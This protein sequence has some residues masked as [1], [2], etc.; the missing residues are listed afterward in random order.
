MWILKI[1]RR[2]IEQNVYFHILITILTFYF[3]FLLILYFNFATFTTIKNRLTDKEL[4]IKKIE[5]GS[6]SSQRMLVHR[7]SDQF[8][9]Q[10]NCSTITSQPGQPNSA[11]SNNS[12]NNSSKL[13]LKCFTNQNY[14]SLNVISGNQVDFNNNAGNGNFLRNS[15][16]KKLNRRCSLCSCHIDRH[17]KK[18]SI[19]KYNNSYHFSITKQNFNGLMSSLT[20]KSFHKTFIEKLQQ[21]HKEGLTKN[22]TFVF[23]E[24]KLIKLLLT[25]NICFGGCWLPI[26]VYQELVRFGKIDVNI[27]LIN[28]LLFLGW[29]NS[30]IDPAIY[31]YLSKKFRKEI[32]LKLSCL[33]K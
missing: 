33:F 19:A 25:I 21:K 14:S 3:P 1:P 24:Y 7:Y 31:L 27:H 15:F 2:Q 28:Y 5:N 16:K 12:S 6:N 10:S 22:Y 18:E 9:N 8:A 13:C 23:K 20:W 29:L 17:F 11:S 4:K 30:G 32:K 26:Y